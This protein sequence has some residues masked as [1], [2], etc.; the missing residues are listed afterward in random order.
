MIGL[1]APGTPNHG[2]C[3]SCF[4]DREKRQQ[5]VSQRERMPCWATLIDGKQTL[6]RLKAPIANPGG[7][8]SDMNATL[9]AI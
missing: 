5:L 1:Y 8:K 3:T 7:R 2:N 9:A 6:R 4:K